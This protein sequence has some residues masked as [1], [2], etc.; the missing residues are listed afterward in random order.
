MS[1]VQQVP[2]R[3][4]SGGLARLARCVEDEVP[5][6]PDEVQHVFKVDACQRRD[7]VVLLRANGTGGV[8]EAHGGKYG[9]CGPI[10][11]AAAGAADR[12]RRQVEPLC[13]PC[14]A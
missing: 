2:K 8:E 5:F 3:Q 1:A 14:A 11:V 12:S 13:R 6:A 4:Q 7:A 10:F 9:M